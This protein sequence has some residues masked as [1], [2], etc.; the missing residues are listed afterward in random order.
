MSKKIIVILAA[1]FIVLLFHSVK[2]AGAQGFVEKTGRPWEVDKEAVIVTPGSG[3][4][5]HSMTPVPEPGRSEAAAI[6]DRWIRNCESEMI[7]TDNRGWGAP[8]MRGKSFIEL[9]NI[10]FFL[11]RSSH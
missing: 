4:C 11:D 8:I 2:I 6:P 3:L 10:M 1:V 7:C 9:F 5:G